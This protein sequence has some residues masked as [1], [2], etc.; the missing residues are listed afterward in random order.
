MGKDFTDSPLGISYY[1]EAEREWVTR[2][3]GARNLRREVY[4]KKEPAARCRRETVLAEKK[5]G[6][7]IISHHREKK[8]GG[9]SA[10]HPSKKKRCPPIWTLTSRGGM[11]KS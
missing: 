5:G 11:K 7:R 3:F 6:E 2:R 1:I 8:K 10:S 9:R 4:L